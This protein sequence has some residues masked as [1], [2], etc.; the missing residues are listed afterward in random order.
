MPNKAVIVKSGL[1][2]VSATKFNP[3]EAILTAQNADYVKSSA[4]AVGKCAPVNYTWNKS[5]VNS[6]DVWYA[7]AYLVYNLGGAEHTVYGKLVTLTAT[8]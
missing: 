6:G 5:N 1:V 7:R 8:A 3:N 2:A 4:K